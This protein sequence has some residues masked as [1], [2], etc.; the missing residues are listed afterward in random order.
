MPAT[1]FVIRFVQRRAHGWE[2]HPAVGGGGYLFFA[3]I[4][5]RAT[6]GR[7][8]KLFSVCVEQRRGKDILF[9]SK[10]TCREHNSQSKAY[11]LCGKER[12]SALE[13]SS[14]CFPFFVRA[15]LCLRWGGMQITLIVFAE[16]KMHC[17][18]ANR[19]TSFAREMH[20]SKKLFM[21]NFHERVHYLFRAAACERERLAAVEIY[22]KD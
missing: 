15:S 16:R 7:Q 2:F 5:R 19:Y 17:S 21:Q 3:S 9:A 6:D 12:G 1:P 13:V 22:W 18:A 20:L 10:Q 14:L 8:D 4:C 11:F